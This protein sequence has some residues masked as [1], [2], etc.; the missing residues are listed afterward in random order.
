MS[1]KEAPPSEL[2]VFLVTPSSNL[3]GPAADLSD[4]NG[5]SCRRRKKHTK[6]HLGCVACKKRRVKVYTSTIV[7]C[8]AAQL[9]A[10][11]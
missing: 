4:I 9:T 5:V 6:S 3:N 1:V 7:P 2:L 8:E 11:R 10:E